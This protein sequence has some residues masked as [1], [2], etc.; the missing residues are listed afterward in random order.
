M[1]VREHCRYQLVLSRELYSPLWSECRELSYVKGTWYGLQPITW[2]ADCSLSVSF[3]YYWC[4]L[5]K[6]FKKKYSHLQI[7]SFQRGCR[8][9]IP[10]NTYHTYTEYLPK[11][12]LYFPFSSV[13]VILSLTLLPVTAW[14]CVPRKWPNT[15]ALHSQVEKTLI[16]NI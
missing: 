7:Q 3:K 13:T 6:P 2:G 1:T 10:Q 4:S 16:W 14:I 9:S 15:I 12:H 5:T 11:V 8:F